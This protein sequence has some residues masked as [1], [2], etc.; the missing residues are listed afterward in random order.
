[1]AKSKRG[2]YTLD[3]KQ[4]AIRLIESSQAPSSVSR[5]LG[6]VELTVGNWVPAHRAGSLQGVGCKAP[7]TK[8]WGQVCPRATAMPSEPPS[9]ASRP[10]R[11]EPG[12]RATG[13]VSSWPV[14]EK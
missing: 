6:V 11:Y 13:S 7:V 3:F 14:P 1:M 10:R 9:D 5:T 4:E 2:R 12:L 8:G